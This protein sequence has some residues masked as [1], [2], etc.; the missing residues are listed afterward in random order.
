MKKMGRLWIVVLVLTL[1]SA[2]CSHYVCP[3]YA[4]DASVEQVADRQG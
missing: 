3:A 4:N 1:I 2:G